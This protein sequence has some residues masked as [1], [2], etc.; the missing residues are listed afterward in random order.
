[1]LAVFKQQQERIE[2]QRRWS[3][4]LNRIQLLKKQIEFLRT[5]LPWEHK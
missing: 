5:Q 4:I 3:E 2:R 1:M